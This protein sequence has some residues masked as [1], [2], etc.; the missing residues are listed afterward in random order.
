VPQSIFSDGPDVVPLVYTVP[1]T[2]EITVLSAYAEY[3]GTNASGP[4]VPCLIY[5]DQAG[6]IIDI[7]EQDT[8]VAAGGSAICSWFP[9]VG[10]AAVAGASSLSIA[11]AY[12][13]AT[14]ITVMGAKTY[15]TTS[16]FTTNDSAAF[17]TGVVT[18]GGNP[19]TGVVFLEQGTYYHFAE[20]VG[21]AGGTPVVG[22]DTVSF[23]YD[24][25]GDPF[26]YFQGTDTIAAPPASL[27]GSGFLGDL[28]FIEAIAVKSTDVAPPTTPLVYWARNSTAARG[29]VGFNSTFVFVPDAYPYPGL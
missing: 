29:R 3:D 6:H 8:T 7:A 25:G 20:A 5:R 24:N 17:T 11:F 22:G 19:Y 23:N 21:A 15:I 13:S 1:G 27:A 12:G 14:Q 26:G 9:Q 28:S 2:G 18:I 10:S 16:T 4:F